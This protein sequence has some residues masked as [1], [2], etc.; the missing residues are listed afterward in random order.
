MPLRRAVLALALAAALP[1][2][3]GVVIDGKGSDDLTR[4][5]LDGK[6]LRME[7][8]SGRERGVMIYD[9]D[10][11]R[12]LQLDLEKKTYTEFTQA[13]MKAMRGMVEQ[14]MKNMPPEQRAKM[15][16]SRKKGAAKWEKTGRADE[17]IGKK[18]DVYRITRD[19]EAEDEVC[20][21]PFG[22]F[23]V[24]KSD[25]AAMHAFEETMRDMTA[26]SSEDADMGWA[27]VPGVPLVAWDLEEG[28]QRKESFRATKVEKGPV[29]ASEF[30][31]PAGF[32]KGPGFAEQMKEM[33]QMQQQMSPEAQRQMQQHMSPE[34][35]R[36]LK[37]QMEQMEKGQQK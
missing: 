7:G 3:A 30:T 9:G 17:A 26:G 11:K 33:Q 34:A 20:L 35:E 15:E 8:A 28:G 19:G 22:T 32:K 36:Q 31:V 24:Q 6:K 16:K 27:D 1:A 14:S 4:L 5:V 2:R 37:Q 12:M 21:A 10:A 23:G 18:C 29:A 13:D 25:L